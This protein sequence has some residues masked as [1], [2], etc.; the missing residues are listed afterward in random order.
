MRRSVA[1]RASRSAAGSQSRILWKPLTR[2][3]CAFRAA[4]W[5]RLREAA[6]VSGDPRW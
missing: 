5:G 4:G 2:T 1:I 3:P 6:L